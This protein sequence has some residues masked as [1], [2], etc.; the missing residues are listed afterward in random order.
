M[1]TVKY[2]V[3]IT[4]SLILQ[5]NCKITI[6]NFMAQ[7]KVLIS[8]CQLLKTI[9]RRFYVGIKPQGDCKIFCSSQNPNFGFI[10]INHAS[11]PTKDTFRAV[12]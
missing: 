12:L 8:S 3:F 1:F 11:L 9:Y 10:L 6:L 5:N 4:N 2:N 7:F